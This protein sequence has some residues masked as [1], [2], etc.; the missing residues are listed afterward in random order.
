MDLQIDTQLNSFFSYLEFEK[1]YSVNTLDAYRNDLTQW[2]TYIEREKIDW[3]TVEQQSVYAF[4]SELR[5]E[6]G[7][8]KSSQARKTASLKS[9]YSY[10][11]RNDIIEKNTLKKL[12]SPKYNRSLP[13][14]LRPVEMERYLEDGTDQLPWIQIRDRA[15]LETL[16]SSGMRISEM[17]PL[18]AEEVIEMNGSIKENLVIEGKGGKQRVVFVGVKA[19][20]ALEL[21]LEARTI[22]LKNVL[23]GVDRENMDKTALFINYRGGRLSRRGAA[24][25]LKKRKSLLLANEDVSPHTLRHTFATDML[26]SGADIRVVQEMLGHSSVSTTQNYTHVAKERIQNTFRNCHPHAKKGNKL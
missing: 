13:K 6:K 18:N 14:P 11:E 5:S 15:I 19:K 7:I 8:S 26:N 22:V 3:V 23:K 10:C 4:L 20:E 17:L 2:V 21:Y 24:Y 12:R 9:F 1:H 25:I 16:Y